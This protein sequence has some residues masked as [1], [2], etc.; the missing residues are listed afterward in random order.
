MNPL[1]SVRGAILTGVFAVGA[2]SGTSDIPGGSPGLLE[3]N[4]HQVII[5]CV[6]VLTTLVWSGGISFILYKIVDALVGLRVDTEIETEGLDL[7]LH[8][9]A[10][11]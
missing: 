5:Q 3:G 9:E 7:G 8:G 2:F 1:S 11:R 6:G 4:P 10:V